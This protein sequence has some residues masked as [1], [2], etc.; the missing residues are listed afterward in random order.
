PWVIAS[1]FPL[2]VDGSV[3]LADDLYCHLFR[4]E[5]PRRSL[6]CLR[7]HLAARFADRH[8]WASLV[9]Y[10][11]MPSEFDRQ[12]ETFRSRA[13]LERRN[14]AYS[15]VD[16]L[17][18]KRIQEQAKRSDR[19]LPFGALPE[20]FW[21]EVSTP[22]QARKAVEEVYDALEE[23]RRGIMESGDERRLAA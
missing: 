10:A 22:E 7:S 9:I 23:E 11:S 19:P 4:G 13:T 2:T 17:L 14:R 6:Q 5:D 8:D 3:V 1:Q 12:V 20:A 15:L 16:L 21:K 18:L